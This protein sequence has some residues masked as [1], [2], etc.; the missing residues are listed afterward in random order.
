MVAKTYTVAFQGVDALRVVI[1]VQITSG[2]SLFTIVGLADKSVAES[3]E[4]VRS[5]LHTIGLSLPGKHITVNL[6]PADMLKE[7]THYDLPI[8]MALM[9]AMGVLPEDKI[10]QYMMMGELGLDGSI[11]PVAGVLPASMTAKSFD[12]GFVCP[13]EQ[14]AEARWSGVEN[15]VAPRSVLELVNHFKGNSF[16][17][18]PEKIIFPEETAFLDYHDV[19]GHETAKR[20]MEIA[21]VGGHNILMI[22]PP[23]SGKSMLASRLP[24]ILPP[25]SSEEILEVSKIHSVSGLLTQGNLITR[26]PFRD[27]H[28]SASMVSLVG[29]GGKARPGEVSLAHQGVLFLDELPEFKRQT[30]EALRQPLETGY[31]SVSRAQAH[32]VYPARFQLVAAMNPCRCG[33]LGDKKRECLRAPRCAKEY[34]AKISGPLLDRID[35][36]IEVPTISPWEMAGTSHEGSKDIRTRVLKAREFSAHRF[37]GYPCHQNAHADGKI[38]EEISFLTEKAK[39][40]LVKIAQKFDLSARGY[41]RLMRVARSIADLDF[42]ECVETCHVMEAISYKKVDPI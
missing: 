29:G 15:L 2:S 17:S 18:Y 6:A 24:S 4:R 12:M 11:R 26:R 19:K 3:R 40:E 31:I 39:E 25:M 7:G 41:H 1:E 22:G 42:S 20:V 14:G 35:L 21:A 34:Q 5:A 32:V 27:P 28:H 23:G 16:L 13:Y 8:V 38:L 36:H 37:Q 10:S 9:A 30:L 33:Y